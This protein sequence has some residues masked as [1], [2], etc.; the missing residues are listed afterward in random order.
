M[1]HN[2]RP[3]V[4]SATSSDSPAAVSA[5]SGR[6]GGGPAGIVGL[7]GLLLGGALAATGCY[8]AARPA[9]AKAEL[10]ALQDGE[11]VDVDLTSSEEADVS[12]SRVR[13][14][15]NYQ[16]N[17][18]TYGDTSLTYHQVRTLT[19]PKWQG[20]IDEYGR[21]V[22][23]CKR[24]NVP[25][26]IGYASMVAGIGVQTYGFLL[27]KDRPELIAPVGYGLMGFGGVSYLT[28]WALLGGRSCDKANEMWADMHLGKADETAI[29]NDEL[30]SE[31]GEVIL[32][33]NKDQQRLAAKKTSASD[34]EGSDDE[35]GDDEGSDE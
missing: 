20:K 13:F 19:D 22:S 16:I 9:P 15:K 6:C 12:G 1:S 26:Y 7:A 21:L 14:Y 24:A 18:M 33:F 10:P 23:S 29:Y 27:L 8:S 5:S 11:I 34:D 25:R 32:K 3:L 31:I 35:A 4:T 30:I 17:S 28:G 2:P